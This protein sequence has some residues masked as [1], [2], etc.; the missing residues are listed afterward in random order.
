MSDKKDLLEEIEGYKNDGNEFFKEQ[1]YKEAQNAYTL[2]EDRYSKATEEEKASVDQKKLARTMA[3]VF[4]NRSQTAIKLEEAGSAKADADKAI[5]ADPTY[6]KGYYRCAVALMMVGKYEEALKFFNQ[7]L[8]LAPSDAT[9]KKSLAECR[10]LAFKSAIHMDDVSASTVAKKEMEEPGSRYSPPEKGGEYVGPH[11]GQTKEDEKNDSLTLTKDEVHNMIDWFKQEKKLHPHY[12][13]RIALATLRML[14]SLPSLVRVDVPDG[15]KITVCGDVHG[16]FYDLLHIF[17]QNGEPSET[18]PYLFN[19]DFVD[20]GSFSAEVVLTLFAYKLLYPQ[21]VHLARGNHETT[22][23]NKLYGFDGE[24]TTKYGDK[25]RDLFAEVF[26]ALPLAHVLNNR[27]FVVHGGLPSN[28]EPLRL[29]QIEAVNRFR[30]PPDAGDDMGIMHDLLWSDP[31]EAVG[32]SPSRRGIGYSF[33]PDYTKAFL[34]RNGL[35]HIIRS[36]EVKPEGYEVAHDGMLTTVFSAPNY[37]DQMGNKGAYVTFTAPE[38]KPVYRTFEAVA[39]PNI[40]PMA[41][42]SALG[43]MFGF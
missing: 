2:A 32:R 20:R 11:L 35:T 18:N 25:M 38:M 3:I 10:K 33:G 6:P 17:E 27:V 12:V 7:V 14:R 30:Q 15:G 22:E 4:A 5:A 16:Q 43:N 8:K 42:S 23:M 9:T 36:H 13:A 1:K 26:C 37:C 29:E 39:H 24:M 31:Q 28:P 41:Y 34:E 40:K 19:G 21:H